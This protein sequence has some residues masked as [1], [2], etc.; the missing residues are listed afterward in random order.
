MP[1][2][3]SNA[4]STFQRL[5]NSVFQEALDRF[6]SVYLDDILIYSEDVP[7]HLHHIKWVLSKLREHHLKAKPTK[8]EFG[9]T[10]LEYL[11]HII[12]NGSVK[13]DPRKT[14][15]ILKWK[16]PENIK[17]LQTFL[18][19]CNYY[20]K[21][22][23]HFAHLASPLYN[24]LKKDVK[25]TWTSTEE[26]AMR[27]LCTALSSHPVLALPDFSIPFQVECDASDV[28]V[29]GVLTQN[30]RPIAY[31][32]KTLTSAEKNYSVHDRELLSI[33]TCCKA[34]RP[35]LDGQRTTVI[36]DHKPLTYLATQPNLNKR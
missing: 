23:P 22:V 36:T 4:P 3:L 18:G 7:S 32:S 30:S 34:W 17:Q 31:L 20:G 24:L 35:Y 1:L 11:G 19:F 29:G 25:W 5:M 9:L 2:G 27:A 14:Q 10:E 21:F 28:A 12:T 8:C 33:V 15:A 13:P 16:S 6:C 26:Q